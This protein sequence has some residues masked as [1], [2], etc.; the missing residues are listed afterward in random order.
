MIENVRLVVT[1]SECTGKTTLAHQLGAWLS[2]P[3]V[4]ESSRIYAENVARELTAQDVEPIATAHLHS[5]A[6]TTQRYHT[7]PM[8][9]LDADL[10]STVVYARHYYGE[11]PRWIEEKAAEQCGALYLLCATDV[12]WVGDGVRDRAGV[13]DIIQQ[14]FV[15][16]LRQVGA[17]VIR[18][19]GLGARRLQNAQAAVRGWRAART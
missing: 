13:R 17:N 7:A 16:A 19:D 8:L 11:C 14:A 15:D 10:V 2:A 1:G 9:V 18:I 5:V 3:V 12:P 4:A 6:L